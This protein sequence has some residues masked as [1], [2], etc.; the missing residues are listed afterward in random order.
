MKREVAK[1][2]GTDPDQGEGN[3]AWASFPACATSSFF[4]LPFKDAAWARVMMAGSPEVMGVIRLASFI[5]II[6]QEMC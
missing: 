6:V 4:L 1:N 2:V 5:L 3:A